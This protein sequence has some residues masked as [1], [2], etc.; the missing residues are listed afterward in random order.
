[1]AGA[2]LPRRGP[3]LRRRPDADL[4]APASARARPSGGGCA[5]TAGGC[6]SWR[7]AWPVTRSAATSRGCARFSARRRPRRGGWRSIPGRPTS[8]FRG[9]MP[10]SKARGPGSSRSTA[11]PRRDSATAIAWPRCSRA[12]P[13]SAASPPRI[14]CVITRR[15]RRWWTRIS[16]PGA[17]TAGPRRRPWPS[18][19]GRRSRRAP[20]RRSCASCS[21][22]G[23][24]RAGSP[25]H[26][27]PSLPAAGSPS[28]GW[29]RMSSIAAASCPS[30]SSGRT[31]CGCSWTPIAPAPPC[32]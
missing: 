27:M 9:S 21:R 10:S 20:T 3:H 31:T 22:R 29:R 19:I 23:A 26:G 18:W 12:C 6:S 14:A 24:Y 30:W 13:R 16:R 15:G 4:P 2:G 7:R 11:T 28:T 8:S 1:M 5:T 17:R 25:I 32:S